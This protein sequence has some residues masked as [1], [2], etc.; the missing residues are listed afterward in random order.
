[1]EDFVL[2]AMQYRTRAFD[3]HQICWS[4]LN[5]FLIVWIYYALGDMYIQYIAIYTLVFTKSS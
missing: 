5:D 1:M 2:T 3:E 4:F